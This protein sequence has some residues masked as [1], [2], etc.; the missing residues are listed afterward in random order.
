MV[1][2]HHLL[3]ALLVLPVLTGCAALNAG[4]SEELLQP[5]DRIVGCE[6]YHVE[7]CWTWV[8][9]GD[10][11]VHTGSDGATADMEIIRFTAEE[12]VLK[13]VDFGKHNNFTALYA[14]LVRGRSVRNGGVTWNHAGNVRAGVWRAEW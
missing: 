5:P 12:L 4:W 3:T 13:R 2:F 11:Y 10:Q 6:V 14:G 8:R 9:E 1:M 7:V